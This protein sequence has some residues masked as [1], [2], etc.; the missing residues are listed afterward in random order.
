MIPTYHRPVAPTPS[1]WPQG[2]AYPN[3]S[4]QQREDIGWRQFFRHQELQQL[5]EIALENN[6]D[7]HS[8]ALRI[9]AYRAQYQIQRADLLPSVEAD[10]SGT[11]GRTP[12]DLSQTGRAVTSS[13]YSAGIGIS[14]YEVDFFGRVRSLT[15]EALETYLA[16]EQAERSERLSLMSDV[17][18]AWLTW[19]SDQALL[20]LAQTTEDA[21]QAS[22]QLTELRWRAGTASELDVRQASSALDS[23]RSKQLQY[24]RLVA[25]DVN[26]LQL[27][28]GAP[29]PSGLSPSMR[30][31]DSILL[32][33]PVGLPSDVLQHR[34]DI[35]QAEHQLKAANA[36]IG[37]AR[38]AFF[39]SISL[40]AST[41][42]ASSQLSGLFDS[43]SRTWS[44]VPKLE[45]PIF[46]AGRLSADLDYAKIQKDIN[47]AAYEKAIQ[48]AF[49]EVSD[50]LASRQTYRSQLSV[51][52]SLVKSDQRYLDLSQ[53]R[54]RSGVDGY[55]TVLDAQRSLFSAQQQRI[56]SQL[57][58]LNA[59]ITLYK[60]LG[61]GDLR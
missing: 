4:S 25:Q 41:G 50:G 7:L 56:S 34:P 45:L 46:N 15:Q 37:A 58:Q 33:V 2:R 29:L 38:A 20:E 10:V 9:E 43:G 35:L 16:S 52:T 48:T 51:E 18:S 42:T 39:P 49:R 54:Y 60:A 44:F 31:D 28:L 13:D 26:A 23:A 32:N 61:G 24:L 19:R 55:L 21:Y 1:V 47:V 27:L 8:A 14:S 22:L 57:A 53:K 5:I 36:D 40:T 3:S 6:R 11:R 17:A 30:I 59:E 12:A